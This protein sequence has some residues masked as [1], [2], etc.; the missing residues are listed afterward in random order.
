MNILVVCHYLGDDTPATIYI[1]DQMKAFVQLGHRVRCAV[2]LPWGK[3]GYQMGR[4]SRGKAL[5]L[6]N[7]NANP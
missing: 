2:L 5:E 7:D 1:H 3:Q 4:F 6:E